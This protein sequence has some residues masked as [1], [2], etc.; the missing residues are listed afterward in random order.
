[1]LGL[2]KVSR[3]NRTSWWL[4]GTI[5]WSRNSGKESYIIVGESAVLGVSLIQIPVLYTWDNF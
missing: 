2:N 1:M 4:A 5:L 3:P